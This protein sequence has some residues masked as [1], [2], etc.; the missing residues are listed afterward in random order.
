MAKAWLVE[1]TDYGYDM[2]CYVLA[3]NRQEARK[4][5]LMF[6]DKCLLHEAG[7]ITVR[8][9]RRP[10][11]DCDRFTDAFLVGKQALW[12]QCPG[13]SKQISDLDEVFDDAAHEVHPAYV[14]ED[15]TVYCST[16]CTEKA[17]CGQF[18]SSQGVCWYAE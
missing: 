15:G 6:D 12:I 9:Y 10:D 3:D 13:C 16:A 4:R 5:A 18:S 7:W 11:L 1:T 8:A 17:R 2:G 14:T